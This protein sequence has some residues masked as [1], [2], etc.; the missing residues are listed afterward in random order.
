MAHPEQLEFIRHVKTHL[1]HYFEKNSVL[2]IGSL[3]IN[4]TIRGFFN[5]CEYTGLDVAP[6]PGVDIV[7]DGQNFDAAD[8]SFDVVISCEVMEHNPHWQ[9][10]MANMIRLLKPGGLII[11][12][13]ATIGRKEHGTARSKP[14]ASPL[15]VEKEWNYYRNLTERDIVRRL[16]LTTLEHWVCFSNWN[17]YDLYL[18]GIKTCDQYE[19][20]KPVI[21][22]IIYIQQIYRKRFWS[23]FKWIRRAVRKHLLNIIRPASIT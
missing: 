6:G 14:N 5:N 11:M 8:A 17:H 19:R 1:P 18:L 9:A 10:T 23:Q 20:I 4:G 15:T 16:D 7:C 22:G 12:S 13:C 21:E 3:D 2:E